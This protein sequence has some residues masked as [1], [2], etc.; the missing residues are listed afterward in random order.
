MHLCP[1][2]KFRPPAETGA[3]ARPRGLKKVSCYGRNIFQ[4]HK[5]HT[6]RKKYYDRNRTRKKNQGVRG[7]FLCRFLSL[8]PAA[9]ALC[10]ANRPS[11]FGSHHLLAGLSCQEWLSSSGIQSMCKL[12]IL[13]E[14][15]ARPSNTNVIIGVGNKLSIRMAAKLQSRSHGAGTTGD[16]RTHAFML[17]TP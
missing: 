13:P 3:G 16:H 15:G 17:L 1:S 4:V 14:Q 5:I 12:F 7:G 8:A 6:K 11:A 2:T 10:A 9:D